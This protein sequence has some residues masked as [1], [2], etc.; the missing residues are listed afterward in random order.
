MEGHEHDILHNGRDVAGNWG[1]LR[2]AELLGLTIFRLGEGFSVSWLA[3]TLDWCGD[4]FI[5]LEGKVFV[6]VWVSCWVWVCENFLTTQLRIQTVICHMIF[7]ATSTITR[8][9]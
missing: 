1:E 7:I 8:S 3:G 5:L 6:C 4:M 9:V 2:H